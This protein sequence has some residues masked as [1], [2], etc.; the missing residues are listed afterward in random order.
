M[1]ESRQE[2]MEKKI[3]E[4]YDAMLKLNVKV[5]ALA[6]NIVDKLGYTTIHCSFCYVHGHDINSSSQSHMNGEQEAS[7]E[8]EGQCDHVGNSE[9]NNDEIKQEESTEIEDNNDIVVPGHYVGNWQ[10]KIENLVESFDWKYEDFQP[11]QGNKFIFKSKVGKE[12]T[13]QLWAK[14]DGYRMYVA[15]IMKKSIAKMNWHKL[16]ENLKVIRLKIKAM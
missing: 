12:R 8:Q 14:N 10:K 16:R 13:M 7:E 4:V 6:A 2:S 3:N 11:R 5:N 1:N 9:D 15:G